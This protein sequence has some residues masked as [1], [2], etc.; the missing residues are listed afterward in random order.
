VGAVAFSL[1]PGQMA[2]YPVP[3]VKAWFVVKC[4]ERRSQPTPSF[5]MVRT[6]LVRTL[7]R[8]AVP[9]AM[10]AALTDLKVRRYNIS[11]KEA[12]ADKANAQ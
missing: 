2:A 1:A 9:A 7:L 12:E 8:E 10:E 11:G 5:A 4:E 6:Q 3:S